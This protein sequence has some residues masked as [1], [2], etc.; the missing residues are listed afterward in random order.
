MTDTDTWTPIGCTA[1]WFGVA[2]PH[3][4]ELW[5]EMDDD[6]CRPATDAE[7]IGLLLARPGLWSF[8]DPE[9]VLRLKAGAN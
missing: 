4:G 9:Q 2:E 7:L 5:L 3:E 6:T 8:I 1:W